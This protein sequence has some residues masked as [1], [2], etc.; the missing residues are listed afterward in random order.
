MISTCGAALLTASVMAI[1]S[2]TT[3]GKA[4]EVVDNHTSDTIPIA[5]VPLDQDPLGEP[6]TVSDWY[7][8]PDTISGIKE[9]TWHFNYA[10]SAK[11]FYKAFSTLDGQP[12]YY[13]FRH[14]FYVKLPR[15]MGYHQSGEFEMGCHYNEFYNADTSL[16]ISTG[17]LFYDVLLV[18]YPHYAD[19]VMQRHRDYNAQLGKVETLKSRRK[20]DLS[21]ITIDHSRPE[22]PRADY[23]LSKI[24]LKKDIE[25]REC[26]F[27][28]SIY[29]PDSLV[30]RESEFLDIIRRFPAK[31]FK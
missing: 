6:D 11:G 30:S 23:C 15:D 7:T 28:I 19:S 22:S 16:V 3:P 2:C 18:D 10:D 21:R 12:F 4:V 9:A 5:E 25:D 24:I 27:Y 1:I 31:P 20:E 8:S 26:E 13:N 29:Y 17:A 14:G